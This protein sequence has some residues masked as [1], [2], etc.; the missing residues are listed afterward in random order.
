MIDAME[1]PVDAVEST[2]DCC[3]AAPDPRIARH[4]DRRTTNQLATGSLPALHDVSRH[5]L[6]ELD[7]VAE[8]HPT[9]LELGCGSGALTVDLLTRGATRA[10]GVDLSPAS[11][12][13][14]RGRASDAG[15][16]ARATFEVG[17]AAR[18]RLEPHDW[19]VLDRVI[20]CYPDVEQLL[21]GSIA[22]AGRRYAFTVPVSDGW[23]GA[24]KRA[25]LRL[26]AATSRWRGRPCPG[27]VHDVRRIEAALA[28]A[29]FVPLRRA[30][31]GWW[32]VAVFERPPA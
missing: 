19:V 9:V 13:A 5:L 3:A 31:T 12:D 4:F 20:C 14:A 7:D 29:G 6:G 22:A 26:E 28:A 2:A 23:R 8:V 15:V 17:D 27:Y 1:P 21:A 16:G 24:A 10:T 32:D 18:I 25:W 11:I 30:R